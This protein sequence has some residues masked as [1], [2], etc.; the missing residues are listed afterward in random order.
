ML[1]PGGIHVEVAKHG[2]ISKKNGSK[3]L[4]K[5]GGSELVVQLCG[6]GLVIIAQEIP[7]EWKWSLGE[8][9]LERY[10]NLKKSISH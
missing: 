10:I 4:P 1:E 2:F 3:A 5:F 6:S 9:C 8:I 7:Q